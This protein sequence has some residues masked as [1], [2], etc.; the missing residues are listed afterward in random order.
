VTTARKTC[1]PA[2]RLITASRAGRRRRLREALKTPV[3]TRTLTESEQSSGACVVLRLGK[4]LDEEGV[5]GREHRRSAELLL[6]EITRQQRGALGVLVLAVDGVAHIFQFTQIR[7]LPKGVSRAKG[8]LVTGASPGPVPAVRATQSAR[9]KRIF[10]DRAMDQNRGRDW[11]CQAL[12]WVAAGMVSAAL[13]R[14]GQ[15]GGG[16]PRA[17]LS[18]C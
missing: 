2:I 8:H 12:L 7:R 6:A 3:S 15:L 16:A 1:F 13:P 9:D 5:D 11:R 14:P 17:K 4:L 18:R 10:E